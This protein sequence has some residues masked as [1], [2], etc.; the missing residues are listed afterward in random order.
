MRYNSLQL[1]YSLCTELGYNAPNRF[2]KG[3]AATGA[4]GDGPAGRNP[5]GDCRIED[6]HMARKRCSEFESQPG[7]GLRQTSL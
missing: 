6:S 3:S 7:M 2:W 1:Q 5:F 4:G